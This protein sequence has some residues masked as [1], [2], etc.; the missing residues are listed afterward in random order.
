M[1]T[2]GE[3]RHE[4]THREP[5]GE[6]AD[7][8]LSGGFLY[9]LDDLHLSLGVLGHDRCVIGVDDAEIFVRGTNRVVVI[10]GVFLE[11]YCEAI[12]VNVSNAM[13]HAPPEAS[14]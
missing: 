2:A 6:A 7:R 11:T 12:K 4:R 9:P 14:K 8:A 5:H 13:V 10:E 3:Q 1:A